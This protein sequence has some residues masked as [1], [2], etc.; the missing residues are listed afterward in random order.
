[1]NKE[2]TDEELQKLHQCLYRIL[3]EIKRVCDKHQIPYFILGGSAI[4]AFFWQEIIPWDDDIDVGL[5]REN[6]NRFL[7]VAPS[8]LRPG[9]FLQWNE[10]DPHTPFYF[11]KVRLDNSQF[12]EQDFQHL[13][14]HHGIY[15]DVFPFDKVPDSPRLQKAQ[16]TLANFFN[17]CFMGKEIWMWKHCG[18]C[19]IQ[20]P[21]KR[22]WLPCA[23]N[24]LV[25]HTLSKRR[26]YKLLA[27]S[28]SLWNNRQAT[29]YNMVLMPRDHIAVKSIL[30]PQQVP[31][32]PLTV[33]APADLETYLRHHYRNLRRYI[34][35]EEQQNHR[36]THLKFPPEE[37]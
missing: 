17:C 4:G 26:I 22:P 20:N 16:R 28:Q 6:Y 14:I 12:V 33:T 10:T 11:A 7:Q 1:M 27:W 3:A 29:Y 36:P 21:T 19:Q 23:L 15:V 30:H 25:D 24:W 13:P 34:P 32:G 8:E 2:Y 31:F 37:G 5:T 18:K 9:F 35:K